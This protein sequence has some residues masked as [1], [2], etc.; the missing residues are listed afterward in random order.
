V[1]ASGWHYQVPYEPDIGAALERLRQQVFASG[2]YARPLELVGD[3]TREAMAA[4]LR[5]MAELSGEPMEEASVARLAAGDAPGSIDEALS[6]AMESGT[7]SILDISGG[8][9]DE[10]GFGVMTPLS[11]RGY[12]SVFGTDHPT[13]DA[14]AEA[15]DRLDGLIEERWQGLYVIG[16]QGDTPSS[17][18]FVGVS[19]D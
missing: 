4:D 3:F 9:A 18:T 14:V 6:W 1:G 16:Y 11:T 10:V 7:H 2:D 13:D 8:V 5:E 17:I 12:A 19:G 15:L